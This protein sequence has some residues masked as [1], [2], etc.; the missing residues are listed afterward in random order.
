MSDSA[1]SS[2]VLSDSR[3]PGA[4]GSAGTSVTISRL[5]VTAGG[6]QLLRD[7]STTF[8][9]GEV[10]L[11]LGCS[12]VGK[13]VLL[14][15]LAGLIDESTA[16]IR[17]SGDIRFHRPDVPAGLSA[18]SNPVAVVFQNYAL[19]DELSPLQNVEIAIDHSAKIF[20]EGRA[21]ELLYDLKVPTDRAVSVLSG[22]Q[23]QRLAI[24]R[25]IAPETDVVLYDEPTSGLD[26]ETGRHV[27][28]LI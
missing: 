7:A 26:S 25:A 3:A 16:G 21:R 28:S 18:S 1:Q 14:R 17:F 10:T 24:A 11:L 13:S 2:E 4:V 15:I 8:A 9:P 6:R 20:R 19:L 27:A 12:G 23:Q 5:T 22:G